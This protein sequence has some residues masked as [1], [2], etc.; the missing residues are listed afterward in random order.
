MRK[1]LNPRS[2]LK[3]AAQRLWMMAADRTL[4]LINHVRRVPK[5]VKQAAI[6][7][8]AIHIF[9]EVPSMLKDAWPKYWTE[10]I[11]PYWSPW[12]QLKVERCWYFKD[13]TDDIQQIGTYYSF[14]KIALQYSVA[15]FIIILIYLCYHI[16]DA[17]FYLWNFKQ[18]HVIYWDLLWYAIILQRIAI[19]PSKAD[20][21]ARIKSLF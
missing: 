1:N 18:S 9:Q 21:W 7:L 13:I 11:D 4:T 5:P 6:I 3:W 15:A 8:A 14:C 10:M 19:A 16:V 20:N 17:I 2:R 12:F